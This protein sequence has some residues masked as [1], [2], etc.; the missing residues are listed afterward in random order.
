MNADTQKHHVVFSCS[1]MRGGGAC[2]KIVGKLGVSCEG[3]VWV[4]PSF[5][6]KWLAQQSGGIAYC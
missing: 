3:D 5:S 1:S 4:F 6:A 2:V